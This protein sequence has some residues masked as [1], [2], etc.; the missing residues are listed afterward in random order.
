MS[1]LTG[2][3]IDLPASVRNVS[4]EVDMTVAGQ[5]NVLN[6]AVNRS[7]KVGNAFGADR[8]DPLK[9]ATANDTDKSS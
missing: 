9:T 1:A 8:E 2:D 3:K 7:I 5:D 4:G 6:Q